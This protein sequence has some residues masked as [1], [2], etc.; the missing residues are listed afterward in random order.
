MIYEDQ[1]GFEKVDTSEGDEKLGNEFR[2]YTE[3]KAK[4]VWT[5]SKRWPKQFAYKEE[6][7][8]GNDISQ[9][10]T[11]QEIPRK[12]MY[13]QKERQAEGNAPALEWNAINDIAE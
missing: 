5:P 2:E 4:P 9:Q 13:N 10:H 11:G 6:H 8:K 1:P 12:G 7:E 3:N